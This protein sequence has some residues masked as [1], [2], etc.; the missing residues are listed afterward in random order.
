MK[1]EGTTSVETL[2]NNLP[3]VF[4]D[5]TSTMSNGATGTATV[6]L[7]GLGAQRTLV[8][9]DG[10]RLMPGDPIVPEPDL[11]DIPAALVDHVEVLTGG[12]SAVYG[13][14][15]EAGVV[16]F[17]MR[18]DFEGIEFDGQYGIDEADNTNSAERAIITPHIGGLGFNYAPEGIM[19]GQSDTGTIIMGTNTANGKGN[20]TAY[21]GY[22]NS[23]PVL[24]AARDSRP[25]RQ[26]FTASRSS[27]AA[28]ATTIASIRSTTRR[29]RR[30]VI[31]WPAAKS[32]TSCMAT[33]RR[34]AAHSCRTPAPTTRSS[35]TAHSTTCS[36]PTHAGRAASS[37]TTKS[38][39]SSTST[40][41]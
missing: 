41:A 11:N 38:T 16:N 29:H 40:R 14:D 33:A 4:A 2:L 5:Q 34:A 26:P 21:I 10:T 22:K 20:V 30:P 24:E 13:S 32:T 25:V 12:A 1:L 28:Q 15:A 23:E 9:V 8:L 17:I 37:A 39:K 18:K 36:V 6:D 27:A 7:R 19:D 35:T 3:S 31:C